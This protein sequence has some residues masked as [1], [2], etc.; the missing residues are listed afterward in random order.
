[1]LWNGIEGVFMT[2]KWVSDDILDHIRNHYDIVDVVGQYVSLKKRGRNYF[3]LCPFH[4]EKTP[5]FSVSPE[6]QIYHCFGCGAGGDVIRFVMDIEGFTF[7]ETIEYLA[8]EAGIS[9][10]QFELESSKDPQAQKK[11]QM[12]KA[13]ELS[14]KLYHYMLLETEHGKEALNYLLNRGFTR[15]LIETFYVGF[16]SPSWDMLKNFLLKRGF[17]ADLLEQSGLIIR[18]EEGKTYDRFRKRIMFP[19]FDNHGRVIAFGGRVLGDGQPKYLNS[20][21]TLIFNKSKLLYNL[22]HAKKEIRKKRQAILLEGYVDTISIWNAGIQYGVATLGTSLTDQ[23][24]V[25]LKRYAD[26]VLINYDSDDAGQQAALRAIDILQKAGCTVKVLQ[27]PQGLDPD[28]YI[29]Q[30]GADAFKREILNNA[31][32]ATAFKLQYI[33]KD[34]NLK[35][36]SDRMNYL[37]K[38]L[39]IISDLKHAIEREHYLKSLAQEFNI[40]YQALKNDH[41]QIYFARRKKKENTRDNLTNQWNNNINNGNDVGRVK[42]LQPA[43]YQAEKNLIY[44]MMKD[45]DIA[46]EIKKV[47]GSDFHVEDFSVLAAYLYSYYGKGYQANISHFISTLED[48]KYIKLASKIAMLDIDHTLT[49]E[50]LHDYIAQVKKYHLDLLIQK[51]RE[52]QIKA[53]KNNDLEKSIQIGQEIIQLRHQM[54]WGKKQ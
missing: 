36:T 22:H 6:K 29:Q 53:E 32:T 26:E 25:L 18:T 45:R 9:I 40:S 2:S 35:D 20:P 14:S 54:N 28:D 27:M 24:A 11:E 23:Q 49:E 39:T 19:I 31:M 51:K 41:D 30:F 37:T 15:E 21:E 17:S 50:T 16:A 8:K 52:E 44:F 4:S 43:Y 46:E 5:S 10:P 48:D 38:A 12:R 33:R 13:Y 1:M 42:N 7:Q 47:I 34:Y 3:G